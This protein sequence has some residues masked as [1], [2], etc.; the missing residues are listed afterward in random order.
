MNENPSSASPA[1]YTR[2]LR[3]QAWIVLVVMV[4]CVGVA[5]VLSLRQATKYAS[6][7]QLDYQGDNTSL[8]LVGTPSFPSRTNKELADFGSQTLLQPVVLAKVKKALPTPKSIAE[9]RGDISTS[10]DPQSNLVN[11]V[12]TTGD[13]E[14]SAALANALAQQSVADNARDVR[15]KYLKTALDLRRRESSLGSSAKDVQ[16]AEL[17]NE[18]I[19]RF[20]ALANLAQPVSIVKAAQPSSSPVSP[21]PVRN[22]ILAAVVGLL[23]GLLLGFVRDAFDKRLRDAD[24][25]RGALSLPVIGHVREE[26][27]GGAGPLPGAVK[28]DAIDLEGFS[29]LRTNLRFMDIDRPLKV[30]AITSATPSEGKSTSAA[31]IALSSAMAGQR[32]LL[33]ECDLRRPS[34]AD[35]LGLAKHT[36]GLTDY[37][38]GHAAPQDVLQT[39][40]PAA[41]PAP[42]HSNGNGNGNGNGNQAGTVQPQPL[43]AILAGSP[44]PQPAELL[45]SERFATFIEQVRDAYDLV[46]LDTSPL[47]SV[48][49]T[50]ELLP[51]VDGSLVCVRAGQT[52]RDQAK[53]MKL[54]LDRVPHGVTGLIITGVKRGRA[55]SYGYYSHAYGRE[56]VPAY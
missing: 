8:S 17:Y 26:A 28:L 38:A 54:I 20:T 55:E 49:D 46:I 11:V 6:T 45:G 37:L 29:I 5:L 21:K 23:V 35:R 2:I 33:V 34:L 18:Q 4:L 7:A 43:V 27:M 14:F 31:S 30:V 47:L 40:G 50:L 51:R 32:T 53:A 39:I 1:D 24:D 12:A 56:P 41:V 10:V 42:M 13:P 22:G 9:L 15:A 44:T 19:T 3:E 16:Q 48:A 36:A 25:V 52:T